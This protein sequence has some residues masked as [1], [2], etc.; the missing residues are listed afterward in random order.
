[1]PENY[2]KY[3]HKYSIEI[4]PDKMLII[5]NDVKMEDF[6]NKY[7][8]MCSVYPIKKTINWKLVAEDYHG[9]EICPYLDKYRDKYIWYYPWDVASGCIWNNDTIKN[10]KLIKNF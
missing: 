9:I 10:Y 5:D 1:M 3:K 4:N 7:K 8:K 2:A 6:Y